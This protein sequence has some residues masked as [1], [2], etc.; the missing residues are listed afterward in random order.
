MVG[1]WQKI[2]DF[3]HR[4][5]I[6]L[7]SRKLVH[8]LSLCEGQAWDCLVKENREHLRKHLYTIG[9]KADQTQFRTTP[10][11]RAYVCCGTELDEWFQKAQFISS[12]CWAKRQKRSR[13]WQGPRQ[14]QEADLWLPRAAK[15]GIETMSLTLVIKTF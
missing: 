9:K 11:S 8:Q 3:A 2:E 12:C 15:W 1:K 10:L 5:I 4:V 14:L 13:C 7:R 6:S